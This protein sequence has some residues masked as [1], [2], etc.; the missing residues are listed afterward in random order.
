MTTSLSWSSKL[1]AISAMHLICVDP[2]AAQHPVNAQAETLSHFTERVKAYLDLQKKVDSKLPAL[3][4]SNDPEKI[5]AHVQALAEGIRAARAGVQPGDIFDGAAEQ[6]RRAIEEDAENRSIRDAHA[7]MQEVP[8]RTR[9]K[10]NAEYPKKRRWPQSRRSS[11]NGCRRC[12]T[13]SSTG[14]WGA[15]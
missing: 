1:V 2:A 3:K 15:T 12:R 10:V 14:S 13:G 8:Q 5:T 4:E 6:F 7:A 9:P 11:F